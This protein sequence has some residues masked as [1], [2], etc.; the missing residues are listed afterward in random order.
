MDTYYE[1]YKLQNGVVVFVFDIAGVEKSHLFLY[2]F[3]SED[4]DKY[5]PYLD[6]VHQI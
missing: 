2:I 1:S 6:K 4:K 3:Q 5:Y